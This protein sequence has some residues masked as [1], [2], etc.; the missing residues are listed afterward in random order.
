MKSRQP[1]DKLGGI[2]KMISDGTK[3]IECVKNNWEIWPDISKSRDLW[4]N[5]LVTN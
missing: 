1:D 4:K 3:L 2:Q 5:V